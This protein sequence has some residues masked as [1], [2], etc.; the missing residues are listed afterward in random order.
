MS[1]SPVLMVRRIQDAV[2]SATDAPVTSLD[3]VDALVSHMERGGYQS[4]RLD[5][6]SL[7]SYQ[8]RLRAW[9]VM[10]DA[11]VAASPIRGREPFQAAYGAYRA[12]AAA[13][14]LPPQSFSS[15]RLRAYSL[16]GVIERRG[17]DD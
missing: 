15:F 12:S 5:L 1:A 14:G 4:I 16:P 9:R 17:D 13:A 7:R 2:A 3:L 8:G 6:G 11:L 10:D